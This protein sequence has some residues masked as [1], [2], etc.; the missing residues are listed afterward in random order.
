MLPG[1]LAVQAGAL[2]TSQAAEAPRSR[3]RTAA[4]AAVAV[5]SLS[6]IGRYRTRIASRRAPFARVRPARL[7]DT[8]VVA[9]G[10]ARRRR[11][12]RFRFAVYV[13]FR[14]IPRSSVSRSAGATPQ[15]PP[16]SPCLRPLQKPRQ[17]GDDANGSGCGG[18]VARRVWQSASS[19][20]RPSSSPPAARRARFGARCGPQ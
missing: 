8:R 20:Q 7:L 1:D 10:L 6:S 9:A 19:R 4:R 18:T 16:P 5:R 13:T 3:G 15:H 17:A 14:C 11:G 12:A 2:R